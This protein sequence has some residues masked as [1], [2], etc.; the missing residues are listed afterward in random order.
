MATTYLPS[1]LHSKVMDRHGQ[2]ISVK[3][4]NAWIK[5]SPIEANGSDVPFHFSAGAMDP[6]AVNKSD[7]P[8][9]IKSGLALGPCAKFHVRAIHKKS[10]VPRYFWASGK[11]R[12]SSR[13][14]LLPSVHLHRVSR[15]APPS[16]PDSSCQPCIIHSQRCPHHKQRF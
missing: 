11:A 1:V 12:A 15:G 5:L 3:H 13:S 2:T 16:A 9:Q 14:F 4:L 8:R 7:G 10:Y 6:P